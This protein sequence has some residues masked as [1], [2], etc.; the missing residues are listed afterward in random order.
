MQRNQRVPTTLPAERSIRPKSAGG[1]QFPCQRVDHHV[2][3]KNDDIEPFSAARSLVSPGNGGRGS[4]RFS[5]CS[6][7]FA[8]RGQAA[9]QAATFKTP[10]DLRSAARLQFVLREPFIELEDGLLD[11]VNVVGMKNDAAAASLNECCGM[12]DRLSPL[13]S[14]D[15]AGAS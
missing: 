6:A 10:Q 3:D 1:R 7:S 15:C 9:R 2:A 11:A 14:I 8:D 13:C 12:C 4:R 5:F